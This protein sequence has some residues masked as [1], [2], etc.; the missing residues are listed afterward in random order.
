M[1]KA[2]LFI[3]IFFIALIPVIG[4]AN[5]DN[6]P[7][8]LNGRSWVNQQAFIDSGSRCSTRIVDEIEQELI[9][10]AIRRF[11]S[12]YR[13]LNRVAGSVTVPVYVHVIN[14]GAGIENGDV[15]LSQIQEQMII[16]NESYAGVTGGAVTP[17]V[18]ELQ[19]VDRT[20][21]AEWYT[22]TPGSVAER[23][24]KQALR[25]GGADALNLYTA[26]IGNGL[27]GW[28]TFPFDYATN[29]TDD[30]VVVLFSSLPGGE[31]VPYDEGDTA[32][33]EIGHWL[34]LY[35]TFQGRCF[36]RDMVSDTP[37][38]RKYASG[39]PAGRDSCPFRS[40][41]DPITNFMDYSDDACM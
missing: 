15:P 11:A 13:V 5:T 18:F 37:A 23:E 10:E 34:G 29:P 4:S 36:D 32:T 1:K 6:F 7:F 40:G 41:L 35:H 9:E 21:N 30:G 2:A 33:H 14:N 22:M 19:W 24:A 20:T 26:N 8:T 38:E 39:C 12:Q 17:F 27:L 31:A 3:L 16:L 28:S 25:L